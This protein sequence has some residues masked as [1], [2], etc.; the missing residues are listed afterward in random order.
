MYIEHTL[1]CCNGI[2]AASVSHYLPNL[3]SLQEVCLDSRATPE[4]LCILW[5]EYY[6][7]T[8]RTVFLHYPISLQVCLADFH[9][10]LVSSSPA[11]RAPLTASK[12]T[13]KANTAF[14]CI[15]VNL[16]LE[17]EG[18]QGG[19]HALRSHELWVHYKFSLYHPDSRRLKQMLVV[20]FLHDFA[21]LVATCMKFEIGII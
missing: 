3:S 12:R 9:H 21:D 16:Y 2:L 10:Q 8:I 1:H 17:T 7:A 6:F 11:L 19:A 18:I 5:S 4:L 14:A 20:F 15:N 13:A